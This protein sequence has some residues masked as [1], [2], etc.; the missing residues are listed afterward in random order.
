MCGRRL[1]LGVLHCLDVLHNMVLLSKFYVHAGLGSGKGNG[2][3]ELLSSR[4]PGCRQRLAPR[5]QL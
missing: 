2:V 1:G 4:W 5:C 3:V